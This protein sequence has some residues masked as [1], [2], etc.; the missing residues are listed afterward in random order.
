MIGFIVFPRVDLSRGYFRIVQR[1]RDICKIGFCL[2]A[3]LERY[4]Q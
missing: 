3:A 2:E 1:C 4:P